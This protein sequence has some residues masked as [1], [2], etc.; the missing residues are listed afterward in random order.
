MRQ[1]TARFHCSTY[2]G[3]STSGALIAVLT[4]SGDDIYIGG[5]QIRG[6]FQCAT[7]VLL[8][9][10]PVVTG[11]QCE[12]ILRRFDSH[13]GGSINQCHACADAGKAYLFV[14]DGVGEIDAVDLQVVSD[15]GEGGR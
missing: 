11:A 9:R 15:L 8:I 4:G 13:G 14:I 7:D 2:E 12:T 10:Q 6:G 3:G 1:V 5:D